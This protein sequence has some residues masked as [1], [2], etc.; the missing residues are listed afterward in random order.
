[1]KL[2]DCTAERHSAAILE[3]F[4]EAIANSTAIYEYVP[5]KPDYMD[6]WFAAKAQGH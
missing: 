5:F 2:V 1:M 6:R 3:I 4:N